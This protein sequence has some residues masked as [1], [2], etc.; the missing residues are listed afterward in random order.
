MT[1]SS[2]QYNHGMVCYQ[3]EY[4]E[5]ID[6]IADVVEI[7]EPEIRKTYLAKFT[8]L[9]RVVK[10]MENVGID[11]TVIFHG[12]QE[13]SKLLSTVTIECRDWL[14]KKVLSALTKR[15]CSKLATC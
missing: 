5:N 2:N 7:T 11:A 12:K 9:Q 3:F 10:H 8:E 13:S 4:L 6:V 15:F 1:L 14:F